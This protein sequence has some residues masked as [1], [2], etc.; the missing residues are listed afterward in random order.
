[1]WEK[2]FFHDWASLGRTAIATTV[3][4][5]VLVALLR[6]AGQRVLA[7]WYAF[8]LIVT[9]ALGSTFDVLA[10]EVTV[11]QSVVGFIML[12][13]LQFSIAWLIVRKGKLRTIVNP[14]PALVVLH[15]QYC[16]EAMIRHRVDEADVRAAIR[17]RGRSAVEQVDA[18]VLEP[19]GSFSVIAKLDR[20]SASAMIDVQGL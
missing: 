6:I 17:S 18:V 14:P 8:D 13:L 12:I 11:A 15:G 4:Y 16:R 3:T 9:V 7:K 2:I 1:M 20:R 5:I 19:D 10:K